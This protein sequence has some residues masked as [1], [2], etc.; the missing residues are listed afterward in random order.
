[1]RA[2]EHVIAKA[3]GGGTP[4]LGGA[5]GEEGSGLLRA[6]CGHSGT[7]LRWQGPRQTEDY[8]WVLR[9]GFQFVSETCM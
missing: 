1:M 5:Y 2:L 7:P 9:V 8:R 3:G 4:A 6:H